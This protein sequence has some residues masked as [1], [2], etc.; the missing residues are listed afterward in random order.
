MVGLALVGFGGYGFS[1]AQNI[2]KLS[3]GG[4]CRLVAA[5]DMQLASLP[6]QA[7]FLRDAGALLYTDMSE[8]FGRHKA[9]VQGVYIATGIASHAPLTVAALE[10]GFHVHL[11][12]PPAAT[13]QEVD[14]MQAAA[15]R[16]G[17]MCM[18]GFQAVHG[19][20]MRQIKQ[21]IAD[22][23][24]GRLRTIICHAGW[25]R[26]AEYY[27]RND[28]AGKLVRGQSWVLDGPATNA[29]AHQVTN[30][31]FLAGSS[32]ADYA[33]PSA[34]RS[35]LYAAGPVESHNTAGIEIMTDTGIR[36]V[37]LL[38]HTTQEQWG[39]SFNIEGDAGRI[40]FDRDKPVTF[41]D[42]AGGRT[43]SVLP[44]PLPGS[45]VRAPG[46]QEEMI[47]LFVSAIC[48]NAPA[49]LACPLSQARKMVLA[50][51]AAHESAG[52]IIRIDGPAV[53]RL[54]ESTPKARTVVEGMDEAI[55][56][57]AAKGC[58]FGD[59]PARPAWAQPTEPFALNTYSSFP[60]RFKR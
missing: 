43:T 42:A 8:M 22:G 31:L 29:L 47:Q 35:E 21:R 19:G 18:V 20:F 30:A 3:A 40:E 26:N 36:I 1:L 58:L 39:P 9:D 48:A 44:A 57:A 49:M 2:V 17:R 38:S 15:D 41:V 27:A 4:S 23:A 7:K 55:R 45:T 50:I 11:E 32:P 51:D 12:K 56:A 6:E 28:W 60:Q 14:R 52:R 25:P 53:R 24:V 33:A 54:D 59:L 5:A 37:L 46:E 10:Q 13:V 34:V 16:A